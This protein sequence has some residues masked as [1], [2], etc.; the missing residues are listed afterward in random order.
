MCRESGGVVGRSR[1]MTEAV[2]WGV[3]VEGGWKVRRVC[4]EF[5]IL[6]LFYRSTAKKVLHKL[7]GNY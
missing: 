6:C 3:V 4:R 2:C 5:K 7:L 1:C